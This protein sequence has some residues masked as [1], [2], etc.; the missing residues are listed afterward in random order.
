[1]RAGVAWCVLLAGCG[2]PWLET[3]EG[4]WRRL[5]T[6]LTSSNAGNLRVTVNPLLS[7]TAMLVTLEPLDPAIDGHVR[8]LQV[9][10]AVPFRADAEV[11]GDRAKTNAAYIG[12]VVSLNWPIVAT[13][14][15]LLDQTY[16]VGLGL[17]DSG[18]TYTKG[19]AR[20]S[21]LLKSDPDLTSGVLRANIVFAGNTRNDPAVV[22]ATEQ[23]IAIWTQIYAGIG[24]ELQPTLF[25]Y[26][27]SGAIQAP[28]QGDPQ[29]Y[30]DI[31]SSTDFG[32]LNLVIVED[33]VGF[34]DVFGFAGDIPGPLIPSERTAV[35]VSAGYGAGA[36]GLF[37]PAEV[38]ILGETMAHEAGHF[39]GLYHPVEVSYDRWDA[40]DDTPECDAEFACIQALGTNLMF[41]YPV[42]DGFSCI[43]QT[44]MSGEQGDV[45]NRYTGVL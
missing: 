6:T 40:L 23:A 12:H 14:G 34:T 35:V 3:P 27:G 39:L 28:G 31:S 44:Q 9:G 21:V 30:L 29:V 19:T 5:T 7:E 24:I 43:A 42:C 2:T 1:M 11:T 10:G 15:P 8:T 32:A 16:K 45:A 22:A 36:D 13:D 17:V 4:P 41:P 20:V 25:D 18:L 26:A 37:S 33:I 38:Q